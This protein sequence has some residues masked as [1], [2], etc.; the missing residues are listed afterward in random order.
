MYFTD[1]KIGEYRR[2]EENPKKSKTITNFNENK[3]I[4][5]G[6]SIFGQNIT[7]DAKKGHL[8][9]T[10]LQNERIPRENHYGSQLETD[11]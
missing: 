1:K 11:S 8:R 2:L 7:N 5:M 6:I 10:F 4:R 3:T 9:Y